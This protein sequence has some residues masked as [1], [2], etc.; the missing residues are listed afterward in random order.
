M[1]V[2]MPVMDGMEATSAIRALPEGKTVPIVA[3]TAN[4]FEEDR[5]NCL[6]AGMSDFVAKPVDPELLYKTLARW[7]P[8]DPDVRQSASQVP[9]QPANPAAQSSPSGN[10]IDIETGLQYFGGKPDSYHRMLGRFIEM[11][12]HAADQIQ[13]ALDAGGRAEAERIAHSMKGI[14]AMLGAEAVRALALTLEQTLHAGD[15]PGNLVRDFRELLAAM[16]TEIRQMNLE[17]QATARTDVDLAR[18]RQLIATLD[19]QLAEDDLKV[20][21]S[22]RELAPLLAEVLAAN[23]VV[24]LGRRIES[25]DLPAALENLRGIVAE[26]PELRGDQA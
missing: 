16:C 24:A 7:I 4:A 14:T 22:W 26:H 5:Q 23:K 10:L 25:F 9:A 11:H 12:A 19:E 6:A 17:Q 13:G 18:I 21:D 2:Q 8:G 15:D 20:A 3:M 1:D